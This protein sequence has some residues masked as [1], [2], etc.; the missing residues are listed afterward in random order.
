MKTKGLILSGLLLIATFTANAQIK[1]GLKEGVNFSTQSDLGMLWDNNDIKTGFTLGATFDYRF[2]DIL[3]IQTELN[4]KSEGLAYER[5]ESK[6]KLNIS[7]NYH[8]YNIPVLIKGRYSDQLGLNEKWTV[9]FYGGPYYSYLSSAESEIEKDGI[10]TITDYERESKA[11][12]LGLIFGSEV[13]RN[14]LKGE[15]FLD[16]RYEMGLSDV[17]KNDNIK[18][19]V[20]GLGFGYR[21]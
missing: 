12:D 17:T 10:K 4:Y 21:F 9:S 6:T 3:S 14:M 5:N 1:F 11:S 18:N 19:K 20:I 16:I 2:H 13:S 7:T 8:Y 15:L